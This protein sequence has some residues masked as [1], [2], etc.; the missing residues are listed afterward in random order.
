MSPDD[1]RSW[2]RREP[3]RAS[4]LVRLRTQY[5]KLPV[6][7]PRRKLPR[8]SVAFSLAL[9]AGGLI[10]AGAG[11]L[12]RGAIDRRLAGLLA[13]GD[14]APFEVQ[15]IRKDLADL[16]V[17]EQELSN[18]L[19]ARLKYA[20]SANA[21]DFYIVI[22]TKARRM[23]FKYADR[24]VRSAPVEIGAPATVTT[25]SGKRW[26]FVPVTGAF[27][28]REKLEN[29]S[30]TAPDWAYALKGR[31]VPNPLPEIP[32]GLGRY[33]LVFAGG[34]AI[35][36]PP[37]PASPLAGPKPGSFQI[38]EADFAAIWKRVGPDTRIYVF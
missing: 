34:Y 14:S 29:A 11:A 7:E 30:W 23:D 37:A 4:G 2:W 21:R 31:P 12:H 19:D 20:E 25:K 1:S 13:A 16:E 10:V 32:D 9:L 15:R 6:G 5:L 3:M 18:A 33:V 28:V 17:D 36:S 35:H 38:P 27:S 26:V 8:P 22:D 24:V